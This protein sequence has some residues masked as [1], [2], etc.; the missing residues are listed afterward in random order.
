M[1]EA[2]LRHRIKNTV[3]H[4]LIDVDSAGT[5]DWHVG[6]L[7]DPRARAECE[8]HG[9]IADSR[10]RQFQARDFAAFDF[11]IAMD[12]SNRTNLLRLPDADNSKVRLLREWIGEPDSDVPDPYYGGPENFRSCFELVSRCIDALEADLRNRLVSSGKMESNG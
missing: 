3:L 6:E 1:A 7:P 12:R 10:A 9:I 8:A 5:G 2:L 11:V 4:D